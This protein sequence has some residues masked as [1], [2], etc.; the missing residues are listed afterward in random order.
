LLGRTVA[1]Y[2]QLA[3]DWPRTSDAYRA[4]VPELTSVDAWRRVF[5]RP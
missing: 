5:E 2:R 1:L 4:A 3:A